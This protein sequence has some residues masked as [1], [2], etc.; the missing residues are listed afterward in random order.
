[1]IDRSPLT[2]PGALQLIATCALAILP[3]FFFQPWPFTA[4]ALA[5]FAWR[6]WLTRSRLIAPPKLLLLLIAFLGVGLAILLFHTVIGKDAGLAILSLMLPL[7]LLETRSARDARVTMLLS[8][9]LLTGQLLMAQT[10]AMA[11]VVTACTLAILATTAS[12][13]RP[14]I[15]LRKSF[16]VALR[17]LA[18]GLPLMLVLFLLFPRID[19]P[20]W[21]MPLDLNSA[22]SGLSDSMSP[23]SI[24]NLIKSG[25]IAFRVSFNG[26]PPPA[27]QLYWR[28]VVLNNFDGYTWESGLAFPRKEPAYTPSGPAYRY[29]LTLEAQ[30]RPWLMGLDYPASGIP[31]VQYMSDL[32]IR[33]PRPVTNRMRMEI[34][35]Y[36]A[37]PVGLDEMRQIISS[38]LRLPPTSNPRTQA[39]G[40]ELAERNSNPAA[41]VSAGIAAMQKAKLIYTLEP[42]PLGR[43]AADEF[44]FDSKRGFCEHFSST[45]VIMMRAAGVPARVVTGYQGGEWNPVDGTLVVR[46]S[47]AHAWAEVWLEK[48]GWMRVDPTAASAPQRIDAGLAGALPNDDTLP[49]S[50]RKDIPLL[51]TLR[52][53]WE[54]VN[55]AW[56]QW[57]L[58]YNAERQLGLL[59]ALGLPEADWRQLIGALTACVMLWMAVLALRSLPRRARLD[60]LGRCWQRFC[61]LLAH[62]GIPCLPWEAPGDFARR[63]AQA[64]PPLAGEIEHIGEEYAMLRYGRRSPSPA[65]IA[66]LE[67]RIK[68]LKH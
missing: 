34:A 24:S 13:Q 38:A 15:P 66:R 67:A 51:A 2:G 8:C 57:V 5:L 31:D 64:L 40:R 17:L 68:A 19:G 1:M 44:L 54:A 45:F 55:N 52:Y 65:D 35:S 32:S 47:D 36:P 21:R 46:Q 43:Q 42:P 23:G 18:S 62:Q 7:K 33:A 41:R 48:R 58:G 12:L 26:S 16:G 20:L 29:S 10:M 60:P 4:F 39:L 56:N 63:A 25:D 6:V 50:L 3:F 59:R 37:T 11:G 14:G 49:L 53:R 27:S 28:A 9:F 22:R 61:T 30:N